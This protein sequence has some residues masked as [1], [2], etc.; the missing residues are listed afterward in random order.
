MTDHTRTHEHT[1]ETPTEPV[2][3]VDPKQALLDGLGGPSGMVYTALP[4]VV[5]VTANAFFALPTTIGIAVAAALALTGWRGLRGERLMS[6]AGGLFGVVAAGSVAAWTGSASGFFL[7]GI[8]AALVGAVVML[9]SLLAR[10][11]LTGVVWNALHGGKHAWHEDRSVLH[12]H[13]VA[14]LAVTAV[15][16]ARFVVKQWLYLAD[17]TGGLAFAKIAMGTPLT[18]LAALVIIWASRHSTKRLTG[19]ATG[20]TTE[21]A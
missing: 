2:P 13:D 10:R 6:A 14:T 7:I 21:Q 4:V 8:W 5:F 1:D 20:R 19:S 3:D 9:A 18:V 12:A 17:A 15:F 11:P 16:A